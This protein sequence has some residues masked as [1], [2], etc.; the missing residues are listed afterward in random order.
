MNI[1]KG[2]WKV[3]GDLDNI[4]IIVEDHKT[5]TVKR[6]CHVA[7]WDHHVPNY[8]EYDANAKLIAAAPDLFETLLT[9]SKEGNLPYELH[10][11][12]LAVLVK[13][14]V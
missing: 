13:A 10:M 9:I 12:V 11:Q 4:A 1:T 5:D 6:I 8:H 7:G 2:T 14:A 3:D